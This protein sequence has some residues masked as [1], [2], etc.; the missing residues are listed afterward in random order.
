MAVLGLCSNFSDVTDQARRECAQR[1]NEV[2][3]T[4]EVAGVKSFRN[5]SITFG[6]PSD[7]HVYENFRSILEDLNNDDTNKIGGPVD[8]ARLFT[9]K[10]VG[11]VKGKGLLTDLSL[12]PDMRVTMT[13]WYWCQRNYSKFSTDGRS[14]NFSGI[15]AAKTAPL[16]LADGATGG[17]YKLASSEE[18]AGFYD[19]SNLQVPN[20][21]YSTNFWRPNFR[22]LFGLLDT[23]W[24]QHLDPNERRAELHPQVSV[25]SNFENSEDYVYDAI[26]M[27]SFMVN[28]DINKLAQ[29]IA[30]AVT[31]Q[32]QQNA[33]NAN[34]NMTSGRAYKETAHFRAR[35]KW[36]VLPLLEAVVV[37]ILLA[38]TIWLNTLP[39]LKS[40]NIGLLSHGP[41]EANSFRV[42]GVESTGK[43]EKFGDEVTVMLMKDEKRWLRLIE[44]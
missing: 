35:W 10:V 29:N 37:A 40:S 13:N 7:D 43:W 8:V 23:K 3:C 20:G 41:E 33:H 34:A 18:L 1:D 36:L 16:L 4:F 44:T 22:S 14:A 6:S 31:N 39:V 32:V 24:Q 15:A 42:N 17:M 9:I 2:Q 11:D 21:S 25:G 38:V 5:L 28:A 27:A 19:A 30:I 12:I 26:G